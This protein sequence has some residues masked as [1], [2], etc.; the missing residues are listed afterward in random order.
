[1]VIG[2]TMTW[3]ALRAAQDHRKLWR[4][5]ACCRG[6][7]A[8]GRV[9]TYNLGMHITMVKKRLR[10]GRECRKCAQATEQLQSRGL[11]ERID[12]VVEADEGDED[13]AGAQLAKRVGVDTAPFFI[14]RD[15]TGEQVYTSVMRLIRDR[16]GAAVSDQDR[17]AAIDP[18]DIGGI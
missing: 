17:A 1:M 9:A 18:D 3:P 16:L 7:I 6:G 4:A 5:A 8:G 2:D 13:S 15:E 11:W 10:D 12:E 14:V